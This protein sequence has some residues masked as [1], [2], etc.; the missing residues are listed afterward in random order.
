MH[1]HHTRAGLVVDHAVLCV[2]QIFACILKST[3]IHIQTVGNKL[4]MHTIYLYTEPGNFHIHDTPKQ[5]VINCHT[6]KCIMHTCYRGLVLICITSIYMSAVFLV[7]SC[8]CKH[9]TQTLKQKIHASTYSE[10]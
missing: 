7:H 9:H 6:C 4:E 3:G 2:I 10:H 1:V 8:S 5:I